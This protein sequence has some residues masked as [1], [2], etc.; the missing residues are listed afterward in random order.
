M[1]TEERVADQITGQVDATRVPRYAGI[2]TFARLPQLEDVRR[3]DVAL[4][5]VPFDSGVTYRPGA[6][7][8]PSAIREASRLLRPYNPALKVR[9]F[10]DQQ[11]VDAGDVA[12][13][14]FSIAEALAT[15]DQRLREILGAGAK[16]VV[17]G[18]DHTVA[19][20]ALRALDSQYGAV[21]LVHFDAHLDTWD[22][23]FEAPYTHGTPFRRAF[24][25]GL[26]R[27]DQCVHVGTRGSLYAS[28]DLDDDAGMGF[29][30]ITADDVARAGVDEV[31]ERICAAVGDRPT[32][33]SLDIDVLDPAHAPGTG[34]PEAGGISSRELLNILRGLKGLR[35]VGCD[36]VEVA[37]AYDHAEITAVAAAHAVYEML[38]IM[39][40]SAGTVSGD[41]QLGNSRP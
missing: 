25:E 7:F 17:L 23:Y 11:V 41:R 13:T 38:S 31:T 18:G 33:I 15:I 27:P 35:L 28:D 20:P 24:E 26:L 5:G 3:F 9:P 39:A 4:V 29:T 1:L 30:V 19:L 6:R 37:P 12:A 8:G 14:P 2:A 22:T 21:A 32:Y 40:L 16:F 36:V 34:T 10:D